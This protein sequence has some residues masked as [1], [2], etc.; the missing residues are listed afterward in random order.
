LSLDATQPLAYHY[1]L[2][3]RLAPLR[4]EGILVIGTGNVIHNLRT[5]VRADG[6]AP[7]DWAVRFNEELRL[8]LL[9]N[10]HAG[11]SDMDSLGRDAPLCI[12]TPE[13]YLPLLYVIALQRPDD[14]MAFLTEGIELGSIGMMSIVI[15][16]DPRDVAGS[17]EN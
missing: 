4:H 11:L 14:A 10:D 9:A 16:A 5:A 1:Q 17:L 2:A 8:R 12:P 15:G 7:Y 3:T 6:V 13:H